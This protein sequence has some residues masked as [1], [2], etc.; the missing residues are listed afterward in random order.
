MKPSW[1]IYKG[2]LFN[3]PHVDRF[4]CDAI[5]E[6]SFRKFL[7]SFTSEE[8][9]IWTAQFSFSIEIKHSDE[10]DNHS[11]AFLLPLEAFFPFLACLDS[12][13]H[14]EKA[15]KECSL[16][17]SLHHSCSLSGIYSHAFNKNF[18]RF[19]MCCCQLK[20]K[21]RTRS[22]ERRKA[23]RRKII[24]YSPYIGIDLYKSYEDK[25]YA[26]TT[27]DISQFRC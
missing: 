23:S 18:I 25:V 10:I 8:I 24:I 26:T 12:S 11:M 9:L 2:F 6:Q 22:G 16:Y 7:C 17:G 21:R 14:Q 13:N 5:A 27:R 19:H 3:E 1:E 20:Q 15:T 4:R